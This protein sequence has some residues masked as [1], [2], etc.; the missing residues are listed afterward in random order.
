MQ[1][2]R[3]VFDDR[4]IEPEVH[5]L[6]CAARSFTGYIYVLRSVDRFEIASSC[7]SSG[8]QVVLSR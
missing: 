5:A 8:H 3:A 6:S 2:L 1:A 7:H 4:L